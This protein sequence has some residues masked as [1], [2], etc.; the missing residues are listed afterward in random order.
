MFELFCCFSGIIRPKNE[1]TIL[2][3]CVCVCFVKILGLFLFFSQCVYLRTNWLKES[4]VKKALIFIISFYPK[5]IFFLWMNWK[6]KS[7]FF[8]WLIFWPFSFFL[9]FFLLLLL[10]F[11]IRS[12]HTYLGFLASNLNLWFWLHFCVKIKKD[13]FCNKPINSS[14]MMMTKTKPKSF[15]SFEFQKSFFL[16]NSLLLRLLWPKKN[17]PKADYISGF[18]V[19]YKIPVKRIWIFQSI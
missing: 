15:F 9:F 5:K 7:F 2:A 6:V 10:S 14:S 11:S 19:W 1:C 16:F 8:V 3:F 4:R 17:N 18:L 13:V 12:S